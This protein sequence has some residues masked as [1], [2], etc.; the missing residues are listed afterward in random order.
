MPSQA[1]S[2]ALS[3]HWQEEVDRWQ[4]SGQSQRAF[5]R[6]HDL[7]YHRF[8]YWRRKLERRSTENRC[9]SSSA[10]VPVTYHPSSIATGLTLV[11]PGGL[12]LRGL[13]HDNLPLVEQLLD[14]L[15]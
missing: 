10:L 12:E 8:I 14:R 4:A 11:L 2:E 6:S 13:S 5:C 1:V 3:D 15:S 9:P 7:S